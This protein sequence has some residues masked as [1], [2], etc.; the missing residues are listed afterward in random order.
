MKTIKMEA[1]GIA[2][3]ENAGKNPD[4]TDALRAWSFASAADAEK[5]SAEFVD[6]ADT[7]ER[8]EVMR[9]LARAREDRAAE[10]A[11]Q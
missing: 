10:R 6:A 7:P 9:E 2:V 1:G 11:S 3:L 8:A 4:G 5:Q